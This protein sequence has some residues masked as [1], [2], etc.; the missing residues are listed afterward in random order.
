MKGIEGIDCCADAH[1]DARHEVTCSLVGAVCG[2]AHSH[3]LCT[4]CTMEPSWALVGRGQHKQS[5]R[6]ACDGWWLLGDSMQMLT[7]LASTSLGGW[8][9]GWGIA[10]GAADNCAVSE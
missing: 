9:G 5:L 6:L 10:R 1:C 3:K 4:V 8:V 2:M 7:L